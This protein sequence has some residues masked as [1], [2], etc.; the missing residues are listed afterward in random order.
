MK[1][2]SA[3]MT[4]YRSDYRPSDFL[5]DEIYLTFKLFDD[6]TLVES[7]L[8]V[9][10][11]PKG[12][13][14][15]NQLRLDGEQLELLSLRFDGDELPRE[16]YN[17]DEEGLTLLKVS[18][19][20]ELTT[21][22]KIYPDKNK[23]LEGLY[24]SNQKYC[25]QCEAEGFRKIT[26]YLDRPDILAKFFV[27]IEAEQS[28]YPL[29][30]S[31]GNPKSSGQL[32]EGRHFCEWEDPFPKPSYLF[33]L[34]AGDLDLLED[35]FKTKTGRKVKLQ[36]F[37]DKGK[38]DQSEF[39]M[40]SLKNAM[41][42]DEE[43][44]NLEYDLDLYMIVA[45]GDFNMGAMENKGLNIFNTKYVLANPQT[46]TDQ[47]F[48]NIESV[49]GHEYFH[50]WTGNRVT[51]RD[52]FQ[53][54]LKEGLTVFRDQQFTEDMRS[55]AVKRID[56]VKVIRSFQFAEDAG[57]MA[58]PIRPDSYIEMNNFYTVTVYNKGAEVIRMLHTLLGEQGFQKGMALYF[59][60]HDGSAATCDDFVAAMADAN[61]KNL[62]TFRAWYAQAGTPELRGEFK[63]S[64]D[65]QQLRIQF[66][67][68]NSHESAKKPYVIPVKI[69]L[70]GE[71]GESISFRLA[72]SDEMTQESLL[73]VE[74]FEQEFVLNDV[75]QNAIP[76]LLRDFSAPVKLSTTLTKE[77]L[78]LLFAHDPNTFTRWDAGQSLMTQF[79]A[80]DSDEL[81]ELIV[82]GFK[83]I[84]HDKQI[85]N[86]FKA[87]ALSLPDLKT[88]FEIHSDKGVDHLI[89]RHKQLKE[90]VARKLENDWL[91]TY[92]KLYVGGD[93]CI[94]QVAAANRAIKN[95]A[96][97]YLAVANNGHDQL[98]KH[99][100][101][102]AKLMTDELAALATAVHGK[103]SD[104]EFIV[105]AFFAKWNHEAL[106]MDKWLAVQATADDQRVIE[107]IKELRQNP[108]FAIDNPNKVRA[109]FG[110]F[111]SL[112]FAHFH[113]K[114]GTGYQMV[115]DTIIELDPL[116]P[117]V[118][119]S[120]AKQ[121]GVAGKLDG[122]RQQL[123]GRQLER[124]L[125]K[126]GL[127]KDVYEIV[128]K[129]NETL[130]G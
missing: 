81:L 9:R 14:S 60:R 76:S 58:H 52:W 25:T 91:A 33:A 37:V 2:A 114:E 65:K 72:E 27:R 113:A 54:S 47:D 10:R 42:W 79:I 120:L 73:L 101:E 106:V 97:Q 17:I 109:L 92:D 3:P 88:L 128:S 85:D 40:A 71:S 119:S 35:S 21:V 121:F 104:A 61:G 83:T 80:A 22:C 124:I 23:S 4:K 125:Q 89:A 95:L 105:D 78:A 45:V 46:A 103:T 108:V 98:V 24:T 118:A 59:Q 8:M 18:D 7:R 115:A 94:E 66:K 90:E 68:M 130:K 13:L 86:A 70:L 38:L 26:Y 19:Q 55:K 111:A 28:R 93:T 48:E 5:I 43:R 99:Q 74:E 30:L 6:H 39:A 56:D 15:A 77:N 107:R 12:D 32:E 41:R 129:T 84:L 29:L 50:N 100:F 112:N 117:Q 57:P 122:E 96:L 110:S 51:C 102:S 62:D 63:Y 34:V 126:D 1:D 127:S 69:G 64:E 67:Q 20:F 87:R 11:N 44:Y 49:I 82:K 116:N 75:K 53:L 31:N 36:L 123:I 16:S